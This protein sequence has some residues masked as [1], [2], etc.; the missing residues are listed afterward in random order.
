[1]YVAHI[2]LNSAEGVEE[3]CIVFGG[4]AKPSR[5]LLAFLDKIEYLIL[6]HPLEL[7]HEVHGSEAP[8]HTTHAEELCDT[9]LLEAMCIHNIHVRSYTVV[10]VSTCVCLCAVCYRGKSN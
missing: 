3:V 7:A 2:H 4:G 10:R 6:V 8:V 9:V 1:M 5:G